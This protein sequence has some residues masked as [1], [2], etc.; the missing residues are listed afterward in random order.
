M[1]AASWFI[2][3]NLESRLSLCVHSSIN[4]SIEINII[5]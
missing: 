4:A 5:E 2:K 1:D 3:C